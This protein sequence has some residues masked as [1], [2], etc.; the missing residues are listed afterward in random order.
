MT[1]EEQ[2]Q[3]ILD[4]ANTKIQKDV[5]DVQEFATFYSNKIIKYFDYQIQFHNIAKNCIEL[6]SSKRIK[7]IT[8][9][10]SLSEYIESLYNLKDEIK[11]IAKGEI[12]G[13]GELPF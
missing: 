11:S 12:E 2:L 3:K 9:K 7:E 5:E 10:D 4:E 13:D 1:I 8:D 6:Y